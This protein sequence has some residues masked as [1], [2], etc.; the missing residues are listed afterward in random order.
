MKDGFYRQAANHISLDTSVI[1]ETI[2]LLRS[3]VSRAYSDWRDADDWIFSNLSFTK[4]QLRT[5]Y[6]GTDIFVD[7]SSAV[8]D[9]GG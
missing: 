5:I 9:E 4:S 3:E 7:F 8:D 6:E 1:R 2:E